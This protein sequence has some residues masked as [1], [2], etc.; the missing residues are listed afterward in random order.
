MLLKGERKGK[1][2]RGTKKKESGRE[3][4]NTLSPPPFFSFCPLSSSLPP[5]FLERGSLFFV[6]RPFSIH[7][8]K[9]G[10][11]KKKEI[12]VYNNK[13]GS[14]VLETANCVEGGKGKKKR[15]EKPFFFFLFPPSPHTKAKRELSFPPPLS[16]FPRERE[17]RRGQ[18]KLFFSF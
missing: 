10:S 17:R 1:E 7:I 8:K 18:K 16:L 2:K 5:P 14:F 15:G 4:K 3:R 13:W 6:E 12:E 11:Q 9:G